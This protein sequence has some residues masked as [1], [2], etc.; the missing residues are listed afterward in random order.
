VEITASTDVVVT[1]AS[2]TL[3]WAICRAL[4]GRSKVTGTYLSRPCVPEGVRGI[5]LDL[6]ETDSIRAALAPARPRLIIHCAAI[7]DPDACEGDPGKAFQVNFKATH[8]LALMAAELG[9]H[10]VYI[11]TDLVFDGSKGNYREDD[12][13][14]P[15]SAYG[16]SKLRGEEAVLDAAPGALVLR[17]ALVYGVAGPA[18]KTFLAR[19]LE[20]LSAGRRVQVF[21]D[22]MRSPIL[23]DDLAAGTIRA[24]EADLAGIYHFGGGEAASRYQFGRKVC[25]VFG[26]SEELL[27]PVTMADVVFPALRPLDAT[28]DTGKFRAA[29]G[30]LPCDLLA[31]LARAAESRF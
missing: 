7:T 6:G 18:R 30:F 24:I 22:Q 17:S 25:K 15:L 26:F 2:G 3:G 14:R 31:G 9:A 20:S 10:L 5:R 27:V 13:P 21:I 16:V 11:S 8:E 19:M 29:T 23:V 12:P 28:L 4:A 1:G